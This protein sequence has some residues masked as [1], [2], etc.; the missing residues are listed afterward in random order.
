MS[1]KKDTVW[2]VQSVLL[3]AGFSGITRYVKADL[4]LLPRQLDKG[5]HHAI[6]SPYMESN[7]VVP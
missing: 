7:M 3:S 6:M 1:L 5:S 4:E 2:P